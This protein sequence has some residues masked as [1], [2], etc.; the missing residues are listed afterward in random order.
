[1]EQA[2]QGSIR[3]SMFGDIQNPTEHSPRQPAVAD[4]VLNR[5]FG[6]ENLQRSLP[7]FCDSVNVENTSV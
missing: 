7:A 5:D 2:A 3:G 4:T 1:M 6:L